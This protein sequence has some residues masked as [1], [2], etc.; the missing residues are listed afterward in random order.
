LNAEQQQQLGLKMLAVQTQTQRLQIL[1]DGILQYTI[2]SQNQQTKSQT[3]LL[4]LAGVLAATLITVVI[5]YSLKK[6]N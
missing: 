6:N 3:T 4:I 5:I 2:S 1:S